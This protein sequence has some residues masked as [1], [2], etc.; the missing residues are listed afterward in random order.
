MKLAIKKPLNGIRPRPTVIVHDGHVITLDWGWY[1]SRFLLDD[2]QFY[3]SGTYPS[4]SHYEAET[5]NSNGEPV[6][7]MIFFEGRK[8]LII[9]VYH[10][11]EY[12]LDGPS[13]ETVYLDG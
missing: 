4:G 10:A 5:T 2:G 3:Y 1:R 8:H 9:K 7:Y 6:T 13:G 11:D 12:W